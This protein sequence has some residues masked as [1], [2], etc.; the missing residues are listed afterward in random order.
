MHRSTQH[1]NLLYDLNSK[2]KIPLECRASEFKQFLLGPLSM[3]NLLSYFP[4]SNTDC[5]TNSGCRITSD[6]H[7]PACGT[8]LFGGCVNFGSS[9]S[10]I[11]PTDNS[12][13]RVLCVP[14]KYIAHFSET[15][16][17]WLFTALTSSIGQRS[18]DKLAVALLL[19]RFLPLATLG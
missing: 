8:I 9:A 15:A 6:W 4:N 13:R 19:Y 14:P 12:G 2:I 11:A 1:S 17:I 10:G 3:F 16:P 7:C 18:Q 5:Q